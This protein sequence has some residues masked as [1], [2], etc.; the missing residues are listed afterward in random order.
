M[1][2]E[3]KLKIIAV[4]SDLILE[5]LENETLN[6]NGK[7][8]QKL[9]EAQIETIYAHESIKKN[10]SLQETKNRVL[11]NINSHFKL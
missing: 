7:L 4:C 3:L 2:K 5:A 8:L 11:F 9:L 1:N 10:V 6:E